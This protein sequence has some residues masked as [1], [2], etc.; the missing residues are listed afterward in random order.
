MI[1]R[2]ELTHW[3]GDRRAQAATA[4][5]I[6]QVTERLKAL[7]F[8]QRLRTQLEV[9]SQDDAAGVLACA[10]DAM[11]DEAALEEVMDCLVG[12]AAADAFFRPACRTVNTEVHSGLLLLDTPL[13]TLFLAIFPVDT[14]AAKRRSRPDADSI[15]FPG[16]R[17]LYKFIRSGAA[18]LSLWEAPTIEA[19]F[20]GSDSGQCRFLERRTLA[21]GDVLELDGRRHSFVIEHAERDLVYV[22]AVT[23][24]GRA[25]L[26]VEYDSRT[27]RFVA[28][29]S[30]DEVSSRTQMMLA[31]LREMERADAIPTF[32]TMLESPHFYARWQAMRE[33]LALDAEIG[34]PHLRTMA[35]RD[36]HP[37]VRSAAEATLAAFFR[38]DT[39]T[40]DDLC[41]E[42]N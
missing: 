10:R 25:P 5:H 33:L 40:S 11:G 41:Y 16:H 26:T 4:A 14:L 32:I 28:A 1:P 17:T 29:S 20:R 9:Q 12:A 6:Q 22:Q 37:E 13:L 27:F 24:A 31:L 3:L 15:V 35:R 34:L 7:P 38:E 36:P 19:A 42:V 30:T 21:D 2:E 39:E 23:S 8:F 18:T